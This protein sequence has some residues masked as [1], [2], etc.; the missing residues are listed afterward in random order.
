[1]AAAIA[2]VHKHI[3][4][5]GGDP[6]RIALAGH[7]AGAHL[8]ALVGTDASF[9]AAHDLPLSAICGVAA[10]DTEAYDLPRLSDMR[11]SP[12]HVNAFGSD[13]AQLRK[14][15]PLFSVTKGNGI[16]PMLVVE[17][18]SAAR[19]AQAEAF[20]AALTAANIRALTVN[21]QGYT[22]EEV[23]S[24]I[25]VPGETVVTPPLMKFLADCFALPPAKS[26]ERSASN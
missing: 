4:E 12:I 20:V 5:Y 18:G 1:M 17:R 23:N 6:E 8:V 7:S 10:L 25:G 26:S 13:P 15:S 21:A 19:R 24:Q 16:P 3:G 11:A 14:A 9:L 2:W 22:H